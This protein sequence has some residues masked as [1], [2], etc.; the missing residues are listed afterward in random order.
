MSCPIWSCLVSCHVVS[1]RVFVC[2]R[3]PSWSVARAVRGPHVLRAHVCV[4]L[5]ARVVH[6]LALTL[7]N[8]TCGSVLLFVVMGSSMCSRVARP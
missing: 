2:S 6:G 7:C 4:A 3:V 1:Q 5:G 8:H